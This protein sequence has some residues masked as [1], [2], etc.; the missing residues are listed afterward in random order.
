MAARDDATRVTNAFTGR[1]ARAITNRF[2]AEMAALEAGL[3]DFPLPLAL[4]QPLGAA[5]I[6]RGSTDFS[7]IY[8]GQAAALARGL[9][10]T[11]LFACLV[12]ETEA[13]W[14]GLVRAGHPARSRARKPAKKP[15]ARRRAPRRR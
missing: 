4:T 2:V 3:P 9:P 12:E 14:A 5:A 15:R 11:A 1:P 13:V 6:Q 7:S 8:A 10:A